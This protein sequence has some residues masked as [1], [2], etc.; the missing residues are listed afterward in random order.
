MLARIEALT[1]PLPAPLLAAGQHTHLF[2]TRSRQL[3]ERDAPPHGGGGAAAA[4]GPVTLLRPKRVALAAHLG[5][6]AS[7]GFL[8]F[9][10]ALLVADPGARPSAREAL[11]HP[12]LNGGPL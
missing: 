10:E 5:A 6:A 9:L 11:A 8:A 2:F 4:D 3:Y 12:W 7:P 1:G